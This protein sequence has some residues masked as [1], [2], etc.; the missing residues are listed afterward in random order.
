M[1][2]DRAKNILCVRLDAM[3]DVLM[4]TPA[5]RAISD[6]GRRRITLMTS[7]SGAAIANYIPEISETIIYDCPWM[8][9][10]GGIPNRQD[11][12]A[13]I[14]HLSSRNFDAAIIFTV[15]SQSPLPAALLCYLAGI[16]R[17]LAHCRENPYHLLTDW[18]PDTDSP[19]NVRH[20]V[21]R[22][23]DLVKHAGWTTRNKQLSL[24]IPTAETAEIEEMVRLPDHHSPWILV[25]PG[26]TAPSRRY[27][28]QLF[29]RVVKRLAALGFRMIFTGT[30]SEVGL[31]EEIRYEVRDASESLAGKLSLGQLIALIAGS[32]LLVTNNTGP[33]HIAAAVG[34]PIVSL[35]ALTNPQHTPWSTAS[36]VLSHD[37][38]CRN[39]FKS[40]CPEGHH[41]CLAGIPPESVV[42]ACMT[43]WEQHC[44]SKTKKEG[45]VNTRH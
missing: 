10:S 21:T 2:W 42:Q 4:T 16:P 7:Q 20:E 41:S 23:G 13:M 11:D 43:L 30:A 3:G 38:P 14:T 27:P 34:T 35:Y 45:Y 18:I 1:P 33:A 8:K 12:L 31:V 37:A 40:V 29:S 5:L 24:R 32:P 6:G 39:C 44:T 15:F 25:H 19:P 28:P 36:I 22:Q 26:A 17:R 9:Q